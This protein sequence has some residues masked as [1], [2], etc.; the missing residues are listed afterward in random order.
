MK[1]IFSQIMLP[2][3][4]FCLSW[5]VAY[6]QRPI[7][8]GAPGTPGQLAY[9]DLI[10][11]GPDGNI[12]VYDEGDV[13]IKVYAPDGKFL[14][15]IAREGQGPGEIARR[16]SVFFGFTRDARLFFTEY[17]MGHRW[18]TLMKLYGELDSVIKIDHPSLFGILKA[19]ALPGLNFLVEFH[20]EHIL[21]KEKDY[22]LYRSPTSL[23]LVDREGKVGKELKGTNYFSRISYISDGADS[24]LPFV[25]RFL[26]CL[27]DDRTLLFADGTTPQIEVLSLEGQ[28][29]R[30]VDTGLEGPEKVTN[31]D[32]DTWRETRKS[33]MRE[34]NPD[35]YFRFG[36]IIEKYKHSIYSVKPIIDDLAVRP[37][38]N[39]LACG[40]WRADKKSRVCTLL[41]S[42]GR[43]LAKV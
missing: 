2:M 31:K 9:P 6:S 33:M 4:M 24:P 38:G 13:C 1:R 5:G 34:R 29:A 23:R 22:Y 41:D 17:F 28:P 32:L 3:F 40:T 19:V 11:E 10:Q 27:L 18:I 43:L 39:I 8:L 21:E 35:W 30:T 25:P 7:V 42:G 16:D 12:Y 20:F 37:D 14:R 36:T 15:K 26:W